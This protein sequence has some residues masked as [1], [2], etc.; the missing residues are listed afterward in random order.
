MMKKKPMH[1]HV[2]TNK[3]SKQMPGGKKKLSR[4]DSVELVL[5]STQICSGLL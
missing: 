5:F 1:V 2:H 3:K 4:G